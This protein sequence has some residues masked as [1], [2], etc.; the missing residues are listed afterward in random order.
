MDGVAA[1]DV[2]A[3]EDVVADAEGHCDNARGCN[4][5]NGGDKDDDRRDDNVRDSAHD[6]DRA[7]AADGEGEVAGVGAEV[8]E[9][10]LRSRQS[11]SGRLKSI[12][13]YDS[14]TFF[15]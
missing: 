6:S 14:L 3:E 7:D 10:A 1:G 5:R 2:A 4:A 12:S 11:A 13:S 15:N 8:P 9:P